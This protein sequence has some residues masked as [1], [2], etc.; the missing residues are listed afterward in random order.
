MSLLAQGVGEGG[1]VWQ[2]AA[3]V[4]GRVG[5]EVEI[6]EEDL[7]AAFEGFVPATFWGVQKQQGH[8]LQV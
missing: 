2:A 7:R 6:L 1:R 5:A 3:A 8:G 4:S